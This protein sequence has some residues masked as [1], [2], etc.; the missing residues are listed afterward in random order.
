MHPPCVSGGKEG[1]FPSSI[2]HREAT[3]GREFDVVPRE[4]RGRSGGA[5][6]VHGWRPSPRAASPETPGATGTGSTGKHVQKRFFR[7]P[8][9]GEDCDSAGKG[10]RGVSDSADQTIL[11]PE[12]PLPSG[13]A[14]RKTVVCS[15]VCWTLI[16]M[17]VC[18]FIY[19][20]MSVHVHTSVCLHVYTCVCV[21]VGAVAC[22]CH[23]LHSFELHAD[24][25]TPEQSENR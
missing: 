6:A 2:P 15:G 23:P 5:R 10:V 12:Y 8:V 21:R 24:A 11:P 25:K 1:L 19:V 14:L 9:T 20:Y 13:A 4:G 16:C 18:V 22:C 3:W 17:C 7:E